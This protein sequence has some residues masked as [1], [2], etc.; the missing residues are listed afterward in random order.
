[1][2]ESR[3]KHIYLGSANGLARSRIDEN[4]LCLEAFTDRAN[5]VL[6]TIAPRSANVHFE[7][8]H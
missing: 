5:S 2:R 6:A 1:M 7:R 8:L 4:A 3:L